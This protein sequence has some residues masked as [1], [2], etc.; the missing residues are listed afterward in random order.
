MLEFTNSIR[1]LYKSIYYSPYL[2]LGRV[3]NDV[4]VQSDDIRKENNLWYIL[5]VGENNKTM[6][7]SGP[8]SM[9]ISPAT[10]SS[11]DWYM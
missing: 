11:R 5:Y 8:Y 3:H 1:R 6:I 7:Y 2:N 10:P 9:I 4:N